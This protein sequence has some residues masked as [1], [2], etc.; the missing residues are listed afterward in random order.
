MAMIVFQNYRAEALADLLRIAQTQ[1]GMQ[2]TSMVRILRGPRR[3]VW[4]GSLGLLQVGPHQFKPARR[5]HRLP[6]PTPLVHSGTNK[7]K[8]PSKQS[9]I[10]DPAETAHVGRL[11]CYPQ[12]PFVLNFAPIIH[13][14][15][16]Y[17]TVLAYRPLF[18]GACLKCTSADSHSR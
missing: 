12:F 14:R 6:D 18:T 17:E 7:A 5:T 1:L 10:V 16:A 8:D 9:Q 2:S 3:G 11:P 4:A 15:F 13:C